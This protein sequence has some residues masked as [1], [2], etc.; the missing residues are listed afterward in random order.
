[1][2]K[3]DEHKSHP[4]EPESRPVFGPF[5]VDAPMQ[6]NLQSTGNIRIECYSA[7][8][9]P[10]MQIPISFQVQLTPHAVKGLKKAIAKLEEENDYPDAF[11]SQQSTQ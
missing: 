8:S 10:G 4:E 2:S 7:L 9:G 5:L 6:V 11:A 1:M 3:D